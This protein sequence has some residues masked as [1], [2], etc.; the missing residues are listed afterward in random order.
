[1][2]ANRPSNPQVRSKPAKFLILN[3]AFILLCLIALSAC[4]KQGYYSFTR[5]V[6]G[7]VVDGVTGAPLEGVIVVGDWPGIGSTLC[8]DHENMTSHIHET[9]TNQRG[10]FRIPGCLKTTGIFFHSDAELG[11]YKKGYFPKTINNDDFWHP[12]EGKPK[13]GIYGPGWVWQYDGAVVEL[14]PSAG[15]PREKLDKIER[16]KNL[17]LVNDYFG[18]PASKCH[19]LKMPK[20]VMATG[21]LDQESGT[22]DKNRHKASMPLAN[23]LVEQVLIEPEMC[24]PDPVGFLMEFADEME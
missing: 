21:H 9:T 23:Y 19:W 11:F 12:S 6:K 14:E 20:M 1:M 18:I 22:R 15:M 7:N 16:S 4:T 17:H 3:A 2:K 13:M 24:H 5:E 8:G 10:K